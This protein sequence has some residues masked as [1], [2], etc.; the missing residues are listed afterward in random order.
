[1]KAELVAAAL[2]T[3]ETVYCVGMVEELGLEETLKCVPIY[4]DNTSALRL[5]GN[6]TNSSR[7][8]HVTL[9]FFYVSEQIPEGKVSIA[10][11]WCVP[12]FGTRYAR[13]HVRRCGCDCC[14]CHP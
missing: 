5:A 9:R 10:Y 11:E 13:M 3:K 1:M 14:K 7:A 8:K 6:N 12:T 4:I 2:A